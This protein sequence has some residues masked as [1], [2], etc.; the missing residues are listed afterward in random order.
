MKS[1]KDVWYVTHLKCPSIFC[2][3]DRLTDKQNQLLLNPA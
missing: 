2:W 1:V 3:T